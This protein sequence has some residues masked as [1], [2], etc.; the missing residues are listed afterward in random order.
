MGLRVADVEV[1]MPDEL[2]MYEASTGRAKWHRPLR[3]QLNMHAFRGD[4]AILAGQ[5]G[6]SGHISIGAGAKLAAQAGVFGDIPAGETW[7][8][9]PAR[10]HREAFKL[11]S[12]YGRLPELFDA[13][14]AVQ[15]KL[16][17]ETKRRT[18]DA[19]E[20]RNDQS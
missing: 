11:Q 15:K 5:V 7:S 1:A 17:M 20:S 18:N 2:S 12:L 14:K 10:P 8:G 6:I 9:Y 19:M 4:G 16:G 13:L 3:T